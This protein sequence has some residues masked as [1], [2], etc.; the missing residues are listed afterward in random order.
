[1]VQACPAPLKRSGCHAGSKITQR[2]PSRP[3]TAWS[4]SPGTGG[5]DQ[6]ER[7]VAISW[8]RWS[9]SPGA[10]IF[11]RLCYGWKCLRPALFPKALGDLQRFDIQVVS[12]GHFVTGL[13][14]VA[15]A[16]RHGEFI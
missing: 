10:R 4:Q 11:A 15:T 8:N 9:Q 2:C 14:M 16:K 3:S 7:L 5:R 13:P 6:S 12:L 1:S